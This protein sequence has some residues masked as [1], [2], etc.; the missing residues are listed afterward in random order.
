[1]PGTGDIRDKVG[2]LLALG[3]SGAEIA[4]ELGISPATVCYHKQRLGVAPDSKCARRYDWDEI[5]RYYDQGYSL[6]ECQA[7]FGF[8][9]KT[10]YDAVQRREIFPRPQALPIA[11]LF[12][13]G[14]A[15][16]RNH[17]K[18]RLL[19]AGI[20]EDRCEH[21][22][23]SDWQGAPL[24]LALHH[25]NGDGRDNRLENLQLLCPNCHSQTPNFGVK[26][27]KQRHAAG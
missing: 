23:I 14:P 20:K 19:G 15:R 11:Q 22:G 24:S 10:W 27:W 18:L 13:T 25:V 12:V 17:L 6:R 3:K 26:N 1:L 8:A 5:Q 16:N 21:C 7:R 2:Q 4:R 9:R